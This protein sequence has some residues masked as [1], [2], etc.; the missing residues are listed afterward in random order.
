MFFEK[1]EATKASG[2]LRRTESMP[3]PAA[4]E[5]ALSQMRRVVRESYSNAQRH[6]GSI[7]LK[8]LS[9]PDLRAAWRIELDAM[10]SRIASNRAALVDGLSK[11]CPGADFSYL[12]RQKGMFSYS[13]LNDAQVAYLREKKAVYMVKGGRINVAGLLESTLAY[14][15]DSIADALANA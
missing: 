1:D 3:S 7:A 13:G 9:D 8:V 14:V 6:G 15:C 10:R 2:T 12:L 5:A 11:R 4:A